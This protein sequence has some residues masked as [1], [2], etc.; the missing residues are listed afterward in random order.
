MVKGVL[1]DQHGCFFLNYAA[2]LNI[3]KIAN[4]LVVLNFF[5]R[6]FAFYEL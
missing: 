1:I 5:L 2:V 4:F 6:Y 3:Y